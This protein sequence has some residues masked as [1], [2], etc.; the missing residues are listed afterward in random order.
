MMHLS[1]NG[2]YFFFTEHTWH[3]PFINNSEVGNA[4]SGCELANSN[5]K[6]IDIGRK[7]F[8]TVLEV[9]LNLY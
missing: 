8:V 3:I 1:Q 9:Q 6:Y 7:I 5:S 4:D 2:D